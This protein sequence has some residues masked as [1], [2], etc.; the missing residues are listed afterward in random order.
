LKNFK[1]GDICIV[2]GSSYKNS[3]NIGKIIIL[4]GLPFGHHWKNPNGE[5]M[6]L[7]TWHFDGAELIS[8]DGESLTF[9]DELFIKKLEDS[10]EDDEMIAIAGKPISLKKEVA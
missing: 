8:W 4:K 10:Q 3:P 6:F 9:V 7:K 1:S 2:V 5:I